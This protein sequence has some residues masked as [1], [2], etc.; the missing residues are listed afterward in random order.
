MKILID[1]NISF[2]LIAH[3][4]QV[5]PNIHHVKTLGLINAPDYQI[6]RYAREN[7]FD[8]ILT[9]DEDFY[10]IVLAHGTPPKIIWLRLKNASVVTQAQHI[11]NNLLLIHHFF[12]DDK[13]DCLE[14]FS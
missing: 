6:F 8:A 3:I 1:Q 4:N 14:I 12:K 11:M 10:N 9:L 13:T 2:R 5:L 7:N